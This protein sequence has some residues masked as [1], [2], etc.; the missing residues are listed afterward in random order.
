MRRNRKSMAALAAA[1]VG[2]PIACSSN[3]FK[4]VRDVDI[5][6]LPIGTPLDSAV[7]RMKDAEPDDR[8]RIPLRSEPRADSAD[9]LVY[10]VLMSPEYRNQCGTYIATGL[11]RFHCGPRNFEKRYL[12]FEDDTLSFNLDPCRYQRLTKGAPT[13]CD[14]FRRIRP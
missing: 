9:V 3:R 14:G 2:L 11:H 8:F 1:L 12:V 13:E 7:A 4:S 10:T 6:A 5:E